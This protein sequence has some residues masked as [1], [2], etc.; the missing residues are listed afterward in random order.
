MAGLTRRSFLGFGAATAAAVALPGCGGGDSGGSADGLRVAWYGGDP[1]HKAMDKALADFTAD[2][3][4]LKL[5]TERAAFGDYW[6]KLAT[7]TAGRK[8]PDVFR[9]SMSY[10]SEYAQR[11]ALLDL[12]DKAGSAIKVDTLDKD[13]AESGRIDGKLM[14][15]GQSSITHATFR[16]P[17]LVEKLGGKLPAEWSWD[18]FATFAKDFAGDAGPGKYGTGDAGGQFQIFE[19][20]SREYGT[21]VFADGKLA[22]AKDV[23]EG[24][25]AYWQ[26]LRKAK[27]APGADVTAEGGSFETSQLSKGAS[28]IEFGWVQ[29]LAFYQPLVKD[30]ELVVGAV[31]G[32][33][34]GS[35][36]GQFLKALDFWSVS[37][38]TKNPDGA[39][40]VIDFL[41]NDDRAV[42][43]IGLTL[44]VPPSKKSRDLLAAQPNTP[45]G[46][47]IAYVEQIEQQVGPSPQPW[48]KG[49][50]ELGTVFTRLNQDIGFGRT[51]PAAAADKFASEAGRV[52]GA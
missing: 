13:V 37:G 14:G 25:F 41:V 18:S 34:A 29:Q 4:D 2:H 32:R 20:W 8:G 49:Y 36:K 26:D 1:V 51:D 38:T 30:A 48:P 39:A 19:V 23:I 17:Q 47:A 27:A 28:P 9:M 16:N 50:G 24:W 42:K 5:S 35:L 52:L 33:T 44:G 6:D 40:Q 10:Y 11:G 43:A 12:T 45:A 15:I 22:V 7:Q 3:A 46:R 21:E 31:P